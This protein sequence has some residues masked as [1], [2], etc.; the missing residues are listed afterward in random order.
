METKVQRTDQLAELRS[1]V[2]TALLVALWLHVPLIAGVAWFLGNGVVMLGGGAAAVAVAVSAVHASWPPETARRMTTAVGAVVMVSL[3]LAATAGGAWQT[4]IHMYYFA[5]MAVLAA[6]CDRNVILTAAA[7]TAVHHL[8]LSFVA[9][10]LVFSGGADLGRVL[11]HAAIVVIE[12]GVLIWLTDRLATLIA[13]DAANLVEADAARAKIEAFGRQETAKREESEQRRAAMLDL[14][15]RFDSTVAAIVAHVAGAAGELQATSQAMA[16]TAEEAAQQTGAVV[17]ASDHAAR[18]VQTVASATE[19]LT[20]SVGAISEQVTRATAMIK[21]SVRQA[22]MSNEQVAGLTEAAD[23][24]GDVVRIISDIAGQTNLLAL[25]ATI[26]AA[27]AGDAGKGFAVVASEVKALANQTAKATEEISAQITAIQ[28]AT[29]ASAHLIHGI[30]E[31]I[32]KV[33]ETAVAIA[34][35][36]QE[37]GGATQEIARNVLTAAE[38]TREVSDAI[39]GIGDAARKTGTAAVQMNEAA[40]GLTK[41]GESLKL[42]VATFLREVRAA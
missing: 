3:L 33:S 28:E 12:A 31:T 38:A 2:D 9:P 29:K 17:T 41:D 21:E 19:E 23:K 36:V 25:N 15:S 13:R 26:E 10:A 30:T 35:A 16:R 27:R 14:S 22:T 6:Y 7:V 1:K 37:Q 18:D 5:V 42:Q 24:I 34:T 8:V 39:V 40:G 11:L 4:D 20:A 32:G